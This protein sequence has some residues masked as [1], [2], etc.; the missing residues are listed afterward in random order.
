MM[1]LNDLEMDPSVLSAV[2]SERRRRILRLVHNREMSAGELA[3]HFEV[4]WPAVSQHLA[5]LKDAGLIKERR[6]GRSR[7]YSTD[8]ATLGPL[9]AVLSQMWTVDLDQLAELAEAEEAGTE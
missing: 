1:C 2:A 5:I 6:E 3:D 9:E 8:S 4:S 7:I